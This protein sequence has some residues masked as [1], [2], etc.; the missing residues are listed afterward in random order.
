M[1]ARRAK[2]GG[3]KQP[4]KGPD[5]TIDFKISTEPH[6]WQIDA[7]SPSWD[8]DAKTFSFFLHKPGHEPVLCILTMDALEKAVQT[9]ELS[10]TGLHQ[11]FDAHRL[12]IELRAAQ[13]LNAGKRD[14]NGCVLVG[15]DDI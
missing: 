10:E 11:I 8:G 13:K 5:V 15:A 6:G 9:N 7:G 4:A 1:R 3:S 14:A 12:M 2:F